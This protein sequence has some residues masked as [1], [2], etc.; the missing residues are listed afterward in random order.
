MVLGSNN[1]SKTSLL[2]VNSKEKFV[3]LST[4]PSV[5]VFAPQMISEE[6]L[7]EVKAEN[8]RRTSSSSSIVTL[9]MHT[10]CI[11]NTFYW[12]LSIH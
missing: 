10:H 8:L 6:M 2:R 4:S 1:S 7:D 3:N 9:G 12:H 11:F 5:T